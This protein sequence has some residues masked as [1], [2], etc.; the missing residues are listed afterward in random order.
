M[1]NINQLKQSFSVMTPSFII[2]DYY[3]IKLKS[4][5]AIKRISEELITS[6]QFRL[7]WLRN[8]ELGDIEAMEWI[9]LRLL[10]IIKHFEMMSINISDKIKTTE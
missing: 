3:N 5:T 1:L 10:D 4:K 2:E 7:D 8:L 6:Q 9:I